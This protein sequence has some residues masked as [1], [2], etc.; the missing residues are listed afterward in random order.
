MKG[1]D[2]SASLNPSWK[3]ISVGFVDAGLWKFP[4]S[5]C[6]PNTE[7]RQQMVHRTPRSVSSSNVTL[8][9]F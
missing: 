3:G 8:M 4:D 7:F 5:V 6:E 1:K 9:C 2:F